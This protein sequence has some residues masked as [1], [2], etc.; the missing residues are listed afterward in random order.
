[1]FVSLLSSPDADISEQAIWAL[2]NIAGDC[3]YYRDMI[4]RAGGLDPLVNI[5]MSSRN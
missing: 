3:S 2:G 5:V 4:L 1:M